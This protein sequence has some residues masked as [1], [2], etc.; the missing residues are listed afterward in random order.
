MAD[1]RVFTDGTQTLEIYRLSTDH[2]DTMLVGYLPKG[3]ILIEVDMWN[4]PAANAPPPASISPVTVQLYDGIKRLKLDVEQI[5]ALHGPRMAALK[6][7]Q[8]AAGK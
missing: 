2:A 3:K 8:A 4:P 5:A 6:D 1:K 7:L